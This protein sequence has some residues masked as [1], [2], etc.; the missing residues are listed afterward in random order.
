M[1]CRGIKVVDVCLLREPEP[2]P[3]PPRKPC[4]PCGR[5]ENVSLSSSF[6]ANTTALPNSI[7]SDTFALSTSSDCYVI[8]DPCHLDKATLVLSASIT[9][10]GTNDA[11]FDMIYVVEVQADTNLWFPVASGA[12][13]PVLNDGVAH[14]LAQTIHFDADDRRTYRV[15]L[16]SNNA[17]YIP[18][19]NPPVS[20]ATNATLTYQKLI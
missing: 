7:A 2:E 20:P 9:P 16:V 1:S 15:V 4:G 19:Y 10:P 18:A 14:T 11:S 3:V 13:I 5:K 6:V 17:S 8:Y 12:P